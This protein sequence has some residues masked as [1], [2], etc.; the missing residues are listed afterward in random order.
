M[1]TRVIEPGTVVLPSDIV[2]SMAN[3]AQVWVRAFAPE[4]MLGLVA[5]GTQVTLTGDTPG[6]KTYHGQIGYVSPVAEFNAQNG[7]DAGSAHANWSIAC[8]SA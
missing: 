2:Y 5:P 7:R 4:T 1:M 6:G 8:A 3:T